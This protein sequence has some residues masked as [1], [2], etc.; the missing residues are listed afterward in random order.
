V[1]EVVTTNEF[2]EWYRDLLEEDAARVT[3][4]VDLLAARGPLLG[5]PYS[6]AIRGSRYA[7]RELRVQAKG[8]PLRVL[9]VFDPKRQAVLLVGGDKTG[10]AKFYERMMPLAEAIWE[11]YLRERAAGLHDEE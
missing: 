8:R 4:V 1:V 10:D 11:E 2:R 6:S 5:H 3:F 9:Y 7:L